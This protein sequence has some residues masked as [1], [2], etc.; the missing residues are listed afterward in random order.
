MRDR[1]PFWFLA[2]IYKLN[3]QHQ[4]TIQIPCRGPPT[5]GN[6]ILSATMDNIGFII[7]NY[8][9]GLQ[10]TYATHGCPSNSYRVLLGYVSD[11]F[12][13][14]VPSDISNNWFA[15]VKQGHHCL[16]PPHPDL[17][18]QS[19]YLGRSTCFTWWKALLREC[20][21]F[22]PMLVWAATEMFIKELL[23]YA[24]TTAGKQ[25][26]LG[27]NHPREWTS[28]ANHF[29]MEES[30]HKVMA[31]ALLEITTTR[32]SNTTPAMFSR[33][34]H[35]NNVRNINAPSPARTCQQPCW[36]VHQEN[37]LHQGPWPRLQGRTSTF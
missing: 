28:R 29:T 25:P 3:N 24:F 26:R 13:N 34:T 15:A 37:S 33:A 1:Q 18:R 12:A 14:V 22:V 21:S 27:E 20:D 17:D 8:A 4:L 23:L 36:G 31:A 19:T 5:S 7:M 9:G 30:Y 10:W 6:A 2:G 11:I 35:M 32:R 16:W